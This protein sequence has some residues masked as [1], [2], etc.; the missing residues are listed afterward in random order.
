MQRIHTL[1]AIL[2]A[3]IA[4]AG[5][6]VGPQYA[7]P[8][9]P[10]IEL[11][12]V[13]KTQFR[14]VGDQAA[15]WTFFEEDGLTQL[16][17][18]ALAHN[19]DIRQAQ[20]SLWAS[21]AILD[22]RRLDRYP[23]VTAQGGYQR[24]IEQQPGSSGEPQRLSSEVYRAGFDAQWEIDL[25]GR[26]HRLAQSALA[27]A[28]AAQAELE[29]MRLTIAADVARSYYERAGLQR[30]LD[31]A[32]AQVQSWG[33]TVQLIQTRVELG[34]G[35]PEDYESARTNLLR[36]EAAIPALLAAVQAS[37]YRLDVLTGQRP[38]QVHAGSH[39]P[40]PAPLVGRL[41]LGDVD[42]LI[43][44]RPDVVRA[45]RLL[46]AS[47]EDVGAATADLYPRLN[48]GGFIGFFALRGGD[49]GSASRAFEIAPSVSWPAFHLGNAQ[50]RLR[51][52]KALSG[53]ALARYE[54]ALLQAQEEVE[55]AVTGLARHQE[56]LASLLQSASHGA[57]ALD[58]ATKRYRAG[59]GSYTAVLE[60]QRALFQ[61]QQEIAQAETA[62]YIKAIALYKALGWG[63][64]PEPTVG[65]S[66]FS[67]KDMAT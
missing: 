36:S 45:E 33:E 23:A 21:R 53:G 14:T 50:A 12:S 52:A 27:R 31:V 57:V 64:G 8:V 56:S 34:S 1:S 15:W 55:N 66:P 9:S 42:S 16:I 17:A 65:N 51:G 7:Q 48:L 38:G 10:S 62:S 18:V 25:F 22:E 2:A 40:A 60:N 3:G 4:L 20:A 30:S 63:I 35:L 43:R 19:H 67:E 11:A 5:C 26:L 44:N 41:P 37:Q 54:Q 24:S 32:R 13:Q 39:A 28:E 61:I 47:T 49:L 6:T 46:A 59:S 58:I 29:L